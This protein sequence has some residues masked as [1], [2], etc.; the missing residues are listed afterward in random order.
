LKKKLKAV[1]RGEIT[2]KD[3]FD[4]W[5]RHFMRINQLS[6]ED[7][8]EI[9]GCTKEKIEYFLTPSTRLSEEQRY[10]RP[11]EIASAGRLLRAIMVTPIYAVTG[12]R[13]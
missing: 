11:E 6:V 13:F 4:L 5:L 8:V 1:C 7:L 9:S 10:A 2:E 12:F 3:H